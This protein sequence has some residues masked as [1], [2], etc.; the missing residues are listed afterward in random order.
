MSELTQRVS[1][2]SKEEIEAVAK[3]IDS[4]IQAMM[5]LAI[6]QA[7]VPLQVLQ[8]D[9]RAALSQTQEKP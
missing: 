2:P 6:A 4:A 8:E 3:V 9:I 1:D 7:C 5:A